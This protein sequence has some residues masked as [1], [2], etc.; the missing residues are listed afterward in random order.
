M[1]RAP[2]PHPGPEPRVLTDTEFLDELEG[3]ARRTLA[4]ARQAGDIFFENYDFELPL[5]GVLVRGRVSATMADLE[6]RVDMELKVAGLS[7]DEGAISRRGLFPDREA[8]ALRADAAGLTLRM[9]EGLKE[10]PGVRALMEKSALAS[11]IKGS[12]AGGGG[13]PRL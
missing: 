1:A 4:R 13:G 11:S 5:E 12:E 6:F 9:I 8:N 7:G 3:W 2:H 10:R